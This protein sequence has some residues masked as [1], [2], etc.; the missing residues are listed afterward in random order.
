[1]TLGWLSPEAR[2]EIEALIDLRVQ[3][4]LAVAERRAAPK[5]WAS[6]SEAAALL[7]ISQRALYARARRGRLPADAIKH[8]GRS[9]LFD[10][11]KLDRYLEQGL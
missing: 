4:A 6:S 8:S 9:L 5:R 3:A 1:M 11:H 10:L 2:A 7:G